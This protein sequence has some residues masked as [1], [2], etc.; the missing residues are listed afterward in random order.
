MRSPCG[1]E[2]DIH[3]KAIV[4]QAKSRRQVRILGIKQISARRANRLSAEGRDR[5]IAKTRAPMRIAICTAALCV[6]V[7]TVRHRMLKI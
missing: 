2:H 3:A 4:E 1:V 5:L 6:P 7:M